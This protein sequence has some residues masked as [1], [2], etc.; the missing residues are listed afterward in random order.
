MLSAG[1]INAASSRLRCFFLAEQL[2]KLGVEV[3][4]NRPAEAAEILFV[5]K[6]ISRD[7]LECAARVK[8]AGGIV[9]Y[10]I[11]DFGP[12][13]AWLKND[14]NIEHLF[15][16]L[17]DAL[18]VDTETRLEV[19]TKDKKYEGVRA[20][21]VLPDP[22]DYIPWR[23]QTHRPIRGDQS[24][25]GSWF[26]NAVNL[27]PAIP[28]IRELLDR[29]VVSGFDAITGERQ[30]EQLA[31]QFSEIGYKAW[32]LSSFAETLQE[33]DFSVLIHDNNLE[34]VQKS[35][36]KM[37]AAMALGVLPFVSNTP[38]Y[39]KT[40]EEAGLEELVINSPHDLVQRINLPNF[41]IDLQARLMAPRCQAYLS[42]FLPENIAI[43]FV[44]LLD[45]LSSESAPTA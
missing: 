7:A 29:G 39:S 24:P 42:K 15:L 31:R 22:I 40:A 11:D 33:Y 12:A 43:Q 23:S 8:S 4:M 20:K 13:L 37:L 10:D 2:S 34:G 28:Y 19:F 27:A 6:R 16:G 36:N 26:G 3:I 44:G 9:I 5:Q 38:A 1:D 17:C 32:E 25:R 18:L 45:R 30:L 35:N 14:P 41:L 21:Y